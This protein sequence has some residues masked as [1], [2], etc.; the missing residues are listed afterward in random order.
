MS[1]IEERFSQKNISFGKINR[2]EF[3]IRHSTIDAES[4]VNVFDPHIHSGCEIYINVT[5]DVSFMVEGQLYKISPGDVVI[6]RPFE[7]H[8]CVYNSNIPHEHY[9]ILFGS[10]GNEEFLPAFF[11]RTAGS[12]NLIQLRPEKSAEMFSFVGRLMESGNQLESYILFLSLINLLS[13]GYIDKTT[14]TQVPSDFAAILDVINRDFTDQ[15]SIGKL[16]KSFFMSTN[17]LERRFQEYLGVSP[18]KYINEKRMALAFQ[19]LE[20]GEKISD[21]SCQ[22]GFSDISLFIRKFKS[23]YGLTPNKYKKKTMLLQK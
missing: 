9:W 14:H 12:G 7:Y 11:R 20:R 17:T 5:G 6:T 4:E 21:V 22:C 16:A 13:G 23:E 19:L 8:N 15:I 1:G 18:T 2:F 10:D 3:L